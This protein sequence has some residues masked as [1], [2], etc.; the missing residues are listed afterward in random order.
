MAVKGN[1]RI[2][3]EFLLEST[4][5]PEVR[6]VMADGGA[7]VPEHQAGVAYGLEIGSRILAEILWP[8]MDMPARL[9]RV[10]RIAH[11]LQTQGYTL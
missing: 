7:P 1:D 11:D 9:A 3:R 6:A 4:N 2:M 5:R 8:E 10:G